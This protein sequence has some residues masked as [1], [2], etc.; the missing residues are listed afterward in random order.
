MSRTIA[1][2]M[3]K[4]APRVIDAVL[5]SSTAIVVEVPGR[6]FGNV[7]DSWSKRV[8]LTK[9]NEARLLPPISSPTTSSATQSLHDSTQ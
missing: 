4:A 2:T 3:M 9:R 6:I 8:P 7:R 1:V 5:F